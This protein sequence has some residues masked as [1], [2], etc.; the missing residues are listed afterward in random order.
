[1][2]E[3]QK[4]GLR[5]IYDAVAL[6]AVVNAVVLAGVVGFF[7]AN[8]TLN[9]DKVQMVAQVL[10]S[11]APETPVPASQVESEKSPTASTTARAVISEEEM[12][13]MQREAE[14]LKTE[15]DQR[16]ALANSI[17][18]KV[19][20]EREAFRKEKDVAAKQ[21][22]AD[23]TRQHDEGFQKQLQILASLGPKT[24]LEHILALND[25]DKAAQVLAAMDTDRAKKIVES[26]K[27]GDEMTKMK[28]IVQRMQDVA[29][30]GGGELRAQAEE[31]P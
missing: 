29:P 22:E 28:L 4:K 5:S 1:M 3:P 19:R 31:E 20:T 24:A 6:V 27:R 11:G 25:P 2:I 18:L 21:Q 30:A 10:R 15:I 23:R 8:G 26:A 14:R 7:A 13:L 12:D 17:M 16:V 9:A